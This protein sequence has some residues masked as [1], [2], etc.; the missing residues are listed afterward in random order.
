MSPCPGI[1][2]LGAMIQ[3]RQETSVT[4]ARIEKA[5]G[6]FV[7]QEKLEALCPALVDLSDD[8]TDTSIEVFGSGVDALI[9]VRPGEQAAKADSVIETAD[10]VRRRFEE[11]GLEI[12]SLPRAAAEWSSKFFVEQAMDRNAD[13][14]GA[15]GEDQ[16]AD[17]KV[18]AG[19][20]LKESATDL[21]AT[22]HDTTEAVRAAVAGG[23]CVEAIDGLMELLQL[24]EAFKDFR[25]RLE[26]FRSDLT[27]RLT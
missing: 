26:V 22:F 3:S 27:S 4:E 23:R 20:I 19:I 1:V 25:I 6:L 2:A 9:P 16:R 12:K 13:I 10:D 14:G 5:G 24:T 7:V 11:T 15:G 21:L 17:P 8:I 18:V